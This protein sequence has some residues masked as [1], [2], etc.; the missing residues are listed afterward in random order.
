MAKRKR[1]DTTC[2]DVKVV[3]T[4][5]GEDIYVLHT[6]SL[7]FAGGLISSREFVQVLVKDAFSD[8]TEVELTKSLEHLPD[9]LHLDVP[10]Q[11]V[12]AAVGFLRFFFFFGS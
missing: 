9:Y 8:G 7:P 1:W 3:S 2:D 11:K 5:P 12:G 10:M 4:L 6:V